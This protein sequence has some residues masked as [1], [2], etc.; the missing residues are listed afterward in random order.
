MDVAKTLIR[1]TVRAFYDTRCA[2]VVDALFI[3]S[4]SVPSF[5]QLPLYG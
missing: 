1:T 5:Y 2:L 3:H 4:V